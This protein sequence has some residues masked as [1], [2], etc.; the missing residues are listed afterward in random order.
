V[1]ETRG[2]VGQ[3]VQTAAELAAA[4]RCGS[5]PRRHHRRFLLVPTVE[6]P[7]AAIPDPYAFTARLSG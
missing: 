5:R 2:A 1:A 4:G 6:S 3:V 7:D